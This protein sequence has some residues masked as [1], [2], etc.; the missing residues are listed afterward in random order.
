METARE[1]LYA[2]MNTARAGSMLRVKSAAVIAF[3][4]AALFWLTKWPNLRPGLLILL[5]GQIDLIVI[6]LRRT[7]TVSREMQQVQES[8]PGKD[9]FASW[10]EGEARFAR[11]LG[12]IEN[13]IR[14]IGFLILGYGFWR[15]T[16]SVLIGFALGVVYPAFAYFG[17]ERRKHRRAKRI[18]QAEKDAVNALLNAS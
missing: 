12:I 8:V 11:R 14:T 1:R 7:F 16:G 13:L 15:A 5:A 18:L 17:M 9:A 2:L 4:M 6:L 3:L 10:F